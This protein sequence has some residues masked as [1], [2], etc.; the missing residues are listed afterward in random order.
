VS[1]TKY[2]PT[3]AAHLFRRQAAHAGVSGHF[4]SLIAQI[5]LA[6]RVIAREINRAG[7]EAGVL[8]STGRTNVQGEDVKPLDEIGNQTFI[9]A[10]RN[11]GL[12]CTLASEEME[13]P[14]QLHENCP[15]G[16]YVLLYDPVDG[17]SN[18]DVNVTI[19]TI[20][21][22]RTSRDDHAHAT[23]DLLRP[24]SEQ[25]AAGYIVYGP[26]TMLVYADDTSV[27]GFTLDRSVGEFFLTHPSI[28]IPS[29][30]HSYAVNEANID[31]WSPA[32]QRLVEMLRHGE[33]PGDR[34]T[35]RYVGSL[36]AD[37]HRTL[38]KGGLYMYPGETGRPDGKLRL[39]YEADPLAFVVERA[40][41]RA[42]DGRKRILEK[43][44]KALHER[45]PL[46]IGSADRVEFAESVLAGR[47]TS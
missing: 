11:S 3:L 15:R 37:F 27:D 16:K 4:S 7:L 45:T 33:A 43:V 2:P 6:A 26:S 39:L 5:D 36:V 24:G 47:L 32:Q 1:L 18:I 20:F 29:G 28:T 40:G 35:A 9:E 21:S 42:S 41:G 30:G 19:G 12:V 23:A 44:P 31:S 14:F 38:L 46:F 22:V 8:G 17:S 10:F 34:S 13:E 25:V